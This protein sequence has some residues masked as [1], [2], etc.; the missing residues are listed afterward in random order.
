MRPV[1]ALLR[2]SQRNAHWH[3][4]YP[5]FRSLGSFDANDAEQHANC[6][7]K[8]ASSNEKL[9]PSYVFDFCFGIWTHR[10]PIE[11]AIWAEEYVSI[12]W[13]KEYLLDQSYATVYESGCLLIEFIRGPSCVGLVLGGNQVACDEARGL[14]ARSVGPVNENFEG[15]S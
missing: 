5:P 12:M 13:L 11:I 1:S 14:N 6:A 4:N 10:F 3:S 9:Y 15:L 8:G 7:Y 2:G